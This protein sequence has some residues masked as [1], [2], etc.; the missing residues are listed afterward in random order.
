MRP[1]L[2]NIKCVTVSNR[3]TLNNSWSENSP[4][5]IRAHQVV[6]MS[7]MLYTQFQT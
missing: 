4:I 7:G 3:Y 5:G 1:T 2:V 6:E